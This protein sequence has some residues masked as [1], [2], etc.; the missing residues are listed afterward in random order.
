MW[1]VA[2]CLITITV[3]TFSKYIYFYTLRTLCT[4]LSRRRKLSRYF[5]VNKTFQLPCR[6]ASWIFAF[7]YCLLSSP[8]WRIVW[9]LSVQKPQVWYVSKSL[10]SGTYK[11]WA[12]FC[13]WFTS[14]YVHGNF[15]AILMTER[16][17]SLYNI[18]ITLVILS[19][20]SKVSSKIWRW[21]KT[22]H[23]DV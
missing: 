13:H 5:S 17:L 4:Q 18:L 3:H 19:P 12:T 6:P 9:N 10:R 8:S 23:R 2:P 7:P 20:S 15:D 22:R 16:T 21:T 1:L 14:F 11:S